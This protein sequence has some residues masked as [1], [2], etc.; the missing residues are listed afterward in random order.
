MINANGIPMPKA[1]PCFPCPLPEVLTS[2]SNSLALV[3]KEPQV[4]KSVSLWPICP[5]TQWHASLFCQAALIFT[6]DP[7]EPIQGTFL[8]LE[9]EDYFPFLLQRG[10]EGNSVSVNTALPTSPHSPL[11]FS[12]SF[13]LSSSWFWKFLLA[14]SRSPTQHEIT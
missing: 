11:F 14:D 6:K 13:W 1:I 3:F 7:L 12:S 9:V 8:L 4:G 5:S 2:S 10:R